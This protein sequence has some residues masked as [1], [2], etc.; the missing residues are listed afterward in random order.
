MDGGNDRYSEQVTPLLV[1]AQQQLATRSSAASKL[2]PSSL[3]ITP[4]GHIDPTG[5]SL[6]DRVFALAHV[7]VPLNVHSSLQ[8]MQHAISNT[9]DVSRSLQYCRCL[10]VRYLGGHSNGLTRLHLESSPICE[11]ER[12][13]RLF[14]ETEHNVEAAAINPRV[15]TLTRAAQME[16]VEN[17]PLDSSQVGSIILAY[18]KTIESLL[19]KRSDLAA[20]AMNELGN[21]HF[22]LKNIRGAYKCWADGVDTILG[23]EDGV[24]EWRYLESSKLSAKKIKK[25]ES[26]ASTTSHQED[27]DLSRIMLNRCGVW[28]C[29]QA[30]IMASKISQFIVNSDLSQRLEYCL[31]SS[32]LVKSIFRASLPHPQADC[33]YVRYDIGPDGVASELVPGIDLFSDYFRC[34]VQSLVAALEWNIEELLRTRYFLNVLPLI[35]FHHYVACIVCRDVCQTVQSRLWRLEALTGLCCFSEAI[36]VLSELV[37]GYRL[38]QAG[39]SSFLPAESRMTSVKFSNGLPLTDQSN[40][41]VM[42]QLFKKSLST[43]LSSLYGKRLTS[44]LNIGQARLQ[45]TIASTV[46]NSPAT[47]NPSLYSSAATSFGPAKRLLSKPVLGRGR[48]MSTK[49]ASLEP[50]GQG[51]A[52]ALDHASD[53]IE[54]SATE[55]PRLLKKVSLSHSSLNSW[56]ETPQLADDKSVRSGSQS[57]MASRASAQ[58][59]VMIVPTMREIKG[60]LLEEAE[61]IINIVMQSII[62]KFI[63]QDLCDVLEEIPS[64]DIELLCHCLLMLSD[65]ANQYDHQA[66]SSDYVLQAM[67]LLSDYLSLP[68]DRN[69]G[70]DNVKSTQRLDARLWLRCR[71]ALVHSLDV[72]TSLAS[73]SSGLNDFVAQCKQGKREAKSLGDMEM[74]LE[75]AFNLTVSDW[76]KFDKTSK[77]VEGFMEILDRSS[78]L[79]KLSPSCQQLV[80]TSRLFLEDLKMKGPETVIDFAASL[81]SYRKAE[82]EVFNLIMTHGESIVWDNLNTTLASLHNIYLPFLTLLSCIK[83]RIGMCLAHQVVSSPDD[84]K[85][86][87]GTRFSQDTPYLKTPRLAVV[88]QPSAVS[89]V[90]STFAAGQQHLMIGGT[91]DGKSRSS[92]W[93]IPALVCGAGLDIARVT[94]RQEHQLEAALAFLFGIIERQL[95]K[96]D[97]LAHREAASVILSAISNTSEADYNLSLTHK[98]YLEIALTYIESINRPLPESLVNKF[99]TTKGKESKTERVRKER[100]KEFERERQKEVVAAWTAVRSAAQTA[101]AASRL[102]SL[103]GEGQSDDVLRRLEGKEQS[104]MP[105]FSKLMLAN[106]SELRFVNITKLLG[107]VEHTACHHHSITKLLNDIECPQVTWIF[108]LRYVTHLRS[109]MSRSAQDVLPEASASPGINHRTLT[110]LAQMH[111]FLKESCAPYATKCVAPMPTSALNLPYSPLERLYQQ[112]DGMIIVEPTTTQVYDPSEH[113]GRRTVSETAQSATVENAATT[114]GDN[115]VCIQWYRTPF[116]KLES[117]LCVYALNC[118]ATRVFS[119]PSK[120][121]MQVGRK[122]VSATAFGTVSKQLAELEAQAAAMQSVP[123]V[124]QK[125]RR[126]TDGGPIVVTAE[127]KE[128][129]DQIRRDILLLFGGRDVQMSLDCTIINISHLARLFRP[130]VGAIVRNSSDVYGFFKMLFSDEEYSRK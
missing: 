26:T 2:L 125:G 65:I 108:L 93:L 71:L 121:P 122:E 21:L 96:N 112:G 8:A 52:A 23:L 25:P 46:N 69:E 79:R 81:T 33:E 80:S 74:W 104:N 43:S 62:K 53:V 94:A 110:R 17:L 84:L 118:K 3:E 16:D 130:T 40:Y 115:E 63:G 64:S 36:H 55:S 60:G 45:I 22:H 37:C 89:S 54:N 42:T 6:Y 113:N 76:I 82:E 119:S 9:S 31:L 73:Q 109:S 61:K 57:S 68:D 48:H 123:A 18:D 35:S 120:S 100:L 4:G 98:A 128:K 49:V 87:D 32:C 47:L 105:T 14:V 5:H 50:V 51:Q 77:A 10:L 11:S 20:Q 15:L 38:P 99:E 106:Q 12:S 30:A 19:V 126:G 91:L 75:F 101:K 114:A 97:H 39:S 103:L 41:K 92:P 124:G 56:L 44:L 70:L 58:K 102:S 72:D 88:H 83:L 86:F 117:I 78:R 13:S 85:I 59:A 127:V 66:P 67:Q 34:N 27:C 116:G 95:A 29:L 7:S 111:D 90:M 24:N 28:G 129:F 107:N 1:I